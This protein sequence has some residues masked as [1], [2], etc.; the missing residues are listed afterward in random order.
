MTIGDFNRWLYRGKRPNV[1]A[2]FLNKF[3]EIAAALGVTP[4]YMVTLEVTGR[5]SGRA[6]LLP[7]VIAIVDGEHYLVSMLGEDVQWVQNVRASGGRVA[8]RSGDRTEV[9]LEEVPID[10]RAPILKAYLR[11]APGA[12]PHIPVHKD[13]PLEQFERIA[14][15]LPTFRVVRLQE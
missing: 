6:I 11:R 9:V 15:S 1:L 14:A 5:K 4:N 7:V 3:Y 10:Q 8:I 2:R 13:A 12:R